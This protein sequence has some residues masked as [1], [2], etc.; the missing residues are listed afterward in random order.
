MKTT[1]SCLALVIVLLAFVIS[2]M[3]PSVAAERQEITA[4]AD[5]PFAG[6][7]QVSVDA[8]DVVRR[9]VHVHERV[10]GL[11]ADAVL[12]YPKWLPGTHA[13]EGPIDRLAAMRMSADGK[14]IRWSRDTVN[15]YAFRLRLPPGSRSLDIDFDYLSPTSAKVGMPQMARELLILEWNDVVLYPAGYYA[16]QIPVT[17]SLLVPAGWTIGTSL[18]M[19]GRDG[20]RTM[21]A[22]VSLE[23]LI[24]SPV[25]AGRYAD[26]IELD[27][28]TAVHLDVFADRADL[29]PTDSSLIASH[30]ALV[31]QAYKLFGSHH[32]GHYDF[33]LA[34]TD[35]LP[36]SGLEHHQSSE[37]VTDANYFADWDGTPWGRDLLPHE[38]THSWNGKFRRPA[39]LWTPSYEVP[40][41]DSLL[42]VY[43][44]QTEYWGYVLTARAGLRS[45]AQTLEVLADL[46]AYYS[47]LPGRRWRPL[48]DTTN[49]EIINPRRPMSWDTWQR[50]EDYYDESA[51][52][53]LEAD[54]LIRERS[55]GQR[56]LDDF[57]KRFFGVEDGRVAPL[58]YTFADVVAALNS[59]EPYDWSSFLRERLDAVDRPAPLD[60]LTRGGYE[61]VYNDKPSDYWKAV[62]TQRKA[63]LLR[64]AIGVD[65]DEKDGTITSVTWNSPAFKASLTEGMQIL[66]VNGAA[67][68]GDLLKRTIAAAQRSPAPIVLILKAADRYVVASV[69][70]T[71]GL[72]YPHLERVPSVPALLDD[73]LAARP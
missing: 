62:E 39:D 30:R 60:G 35:Q 8:T 19:Q 61:L 53:W 25:F 33:L 43:E 6:E 66:A 69:D 67:Y 51:L 26:R 55:H 2:A 40:M 73:I 37:D 32:Y 16:R 58:T 17:A 72:R 29:L 11:G 4:P 18:E 45:K 59:V 1:H 12:W 47:T 36:W 31:I 14:P 22:R 28:A 49:D 65:I 3:H 27:A 38:Y 57:A 34:L 50:F 10:S 15:V 23:R 44:G 7:I 20:A 24:D 41:Q 70:Y 68:S 9:I 21:F 64:Y 46:A 63:V 56:S 42:W 71:G 48:Q 52:F 5:R 54:T 13:P